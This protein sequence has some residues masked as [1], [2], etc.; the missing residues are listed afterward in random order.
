VKELLRLR[1]IIQV[2]AMIAIFF[3][4]IYGMYYNLSVPDDFLNG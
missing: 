3:T 2:V 1:I 4:A